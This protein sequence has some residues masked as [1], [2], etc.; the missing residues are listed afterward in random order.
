MY[1]CDFKHNIDPSAEK[2]SDPLKNIFDMDRISPVNCPFLYSRQ[3]EKHIGNINRI[4]KEE[5]PV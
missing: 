1:I 5:K 3:V 4:K 2:H